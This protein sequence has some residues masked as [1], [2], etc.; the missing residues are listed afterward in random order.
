M[1]TKKL[2]MDQIKKMSLEELQ[3]IN[4][5]G[6]NAVVKQAI[7]VA[8]S[9]LSTPAETATPVEKVQESIAADSVSAPVSEVKKAKNKPNETT[10][11]IIA[12]ADD[13]KGIRAGSEVTFTENNK[14][15]AKVI[16]GKVQRLFDFWLKPERQEAKIMVTDAKGNKT[17]YYRFEKDITPVVA[18]AAQTEVIEPAIESPA[19]DI[20][21][22]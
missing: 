22:E 15:G 5:N 8:I 16:T 12:F 18:A 19:T 3:A 4:T 14:P 17:R 7:T 13:T 20:A 21:A 10:R 1:E 2:S 6:M 9:K 11:T